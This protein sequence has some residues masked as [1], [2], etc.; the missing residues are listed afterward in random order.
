[1]TA[2]FQR[3]EW[4]EEPEIR[5]AH[6]LCHFPHHCRTEKLLL[7]PSLQFATISSILKSLLP[8]NLILW[9]L[10]WFT[11][12]PVRSTQCAQAAFW[13]TGSCA[14]ERSFRVPGISGRISR[15]IRNDGPLKPNLLEGVLSFWS[16][17]CAPTQDRSL[18]IPDR[19]MTGWRCFRKTRLS[20]SL[21]LHDYT[22]SSQTS[23]SMSSEKSSGERDY[24][25]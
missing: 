11:R 2:S 23:S 9:S 1:M 6:E 15:P 22:S 4:A 20:E 12:P 21:F 14:P 10:P 18:P 25:G 19:V 16:P 5:F 8:T 3:E 13:T 7:F 24:L 17:I